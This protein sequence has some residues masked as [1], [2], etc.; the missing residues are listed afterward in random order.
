MK[1]FYISRD[2]I[3]KNK[4]CLEPGLNQRPLDLQS[5]ALPA[6]LSRQCIILYFIEDVYSLYV[7]KNE[8]RSKK[9]NNNNKNKNYKNSKSN[10]QRNNDNT[11][12]ILKK[13]VNQISTLTRPNRPPYSNGYNN[14]NNRR[15]NLRRNNSQL[16]GNHNVK[17]NNPYNGRRQMNNNNN[18]NFIRASRY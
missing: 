3:K 6:E 16:R 9:R 11:Y 14:N 12:T 4:K 1:L 5:N 10:K 2:N 15:S 13:L 7:N 8:F 17:Y 18:R